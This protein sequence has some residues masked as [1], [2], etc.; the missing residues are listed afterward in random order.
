[1]DRGIGVRPSIQ[2]C[3]TTL[4]RPSEGRSK[5]KSVSPTHFTVNA[6]LGF[7]RFRTRP[8][9]APRAARSD[10]REPGVPGRRV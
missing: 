1:M 3:H 6:C 5:K 2:P 9:N 8:G 4:N 7:H 10:R